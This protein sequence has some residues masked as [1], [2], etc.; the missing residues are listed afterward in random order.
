MATSNL[1]Q[2]LETADSA[3][4]DLGVTPSNRRQVETFIAKSSIA[5]GDAVVLDN[6]QTGNGLQGLVVKSAGFAA[7]GVAGIV[8]VAAEAVTGTSG[9]PVK[10]R[11]VIAGE[12]TVKVA[13]GTTAGSLVS[14]TAVASTGTA[15]VGGAGAATLND[16][17]AAATAYAVLL[18]AEASGLALAMVST[19]GF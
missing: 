14:C 11:V 6:T 13:A 8:G 15:I 5:L 10:V 3:G 17:R 18:D 12:A 16:V 9:T 2:Y 19:K 7:A 4:T 1:I